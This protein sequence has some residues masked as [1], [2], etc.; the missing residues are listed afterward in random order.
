MD[1]L[2]VSNTCHWCHRVD[3]FVKTLPLAAQQQIVYRNI[4]TDASAAEALRAEGFQNVPLLVTDFRGQR[5]RF[6]GGP[7]I[8]Q[9]LS[10]HF[11]QTV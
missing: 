11:T 10:Q 8:I 1:I 4:S 9:I 3:A 2:Y 6:L 7:D 5:E